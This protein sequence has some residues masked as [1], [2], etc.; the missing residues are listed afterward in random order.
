LK[1]SSVTKGFFDPNEHKAVT[2][3]T[4]SRDL[5]FPKKGDFLMTRANTKEK[6]GAISIVYEDYNDVF[7]SDKIWNVKIK[8]DETIP[9]YLKMIF[10]HKAFRTKFVRKVASPSGSM[11]NISQTKFLDYLF[12]N[13]PIGKQSNFEKIYNNYFYQRDQFLKSKELIEELFKSLI[14]KTFH[15][16]NKE[17]DE[18]G[19]LIN[20]EFLINDFFE[21]ID[22][23][24]FQ[25]L[26]QYDIELEKLR[27]VLIRTQKERKEDEQF[28]KGII[29]ILNS[30]KV[31]LRINREYK[32]EQ[33]DEATKA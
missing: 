18:I 8:K 12:P 7:L 27:K 16:E 23:S 19:N 30:K 26:E 33:L 21:T 2:K 25:S 6:V 13:A 11:V 17:V 28:S 10:N 31:Q 9:I 32:N 1:V 14:Y 5:V 24:D 3:N 29:Q 22:K 20:D 4:I 15:P